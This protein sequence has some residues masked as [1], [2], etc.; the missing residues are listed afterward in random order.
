MAL[1]ETVI[2]ENP[3]WFVEFVESL[4]RVT[5]AGLEAVMLGSFFNS[6]AAGRSV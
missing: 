2:A 1:L 3:G 4:E 6:N 5:G